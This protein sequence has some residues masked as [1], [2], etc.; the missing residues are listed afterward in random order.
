MDPNSICHPSSDTGFDWVDTHGYYVSS[1]HA[2]AL[3]QLALQHGLIA[4]VDADQT[5]NALWVMAAETD[6]RI[7]APRAME[8]Y[9]KYQPTLRG[10]N[11]ASIRAAGLEAIHTWQMVASGNTVAD[12]R[13]MYDLMDLMGDLHDLLACAGQTDPEAPLDGRG[14]WCGFDAR[15]RTML[16]AWSL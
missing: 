10:E 5:A 8:G 15:Q 16:S 12:L 1:D 9:W 7:R 4:R 3:T 13:G 6:G 11:P 14:C 2:N